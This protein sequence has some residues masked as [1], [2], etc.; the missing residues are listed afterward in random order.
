MSYGP[1]RSFSHQ[2]CSPTC[3]SGVNAWVS[4]KALLTAAI[5]LPTLSL[6][7]ARPC[8]STTTGSPHPGLEL[9]G[10]GGLCRLKRCHHS[11]PPSPSTRLHIATLSFWS[12]NSSTIP[13]SNRCLSP[14]LVYWLAGLVP[15][16]YHVFVTA[17]AHQGLNGNKL[18][19]ENLLKSLAKPRIRRLRL[20]QCPCPEVNKRRMLTGFTSPIGRREAYPFSENS[21]G[22]FLKY[23]TLIF[24]LL[25]NS[26]AWA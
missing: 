8:G 15:V 23:K 21:V 20:L 24:S 2:F 11:S 13:I 5:V 19:R 7:A 18:F 17:P 4:D 1:S 16:V 10:S 22:E 26:W 6:G 3:T 14:I 25:G 9:A 12:P